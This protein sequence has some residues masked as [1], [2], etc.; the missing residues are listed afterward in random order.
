M[1][2][3]WPINYMVKIKYFYKK[4]KKKCCVDQYSQMIKFNWKPKI[5]YLKK[6]YLKFT[7]RELILNKLQL[8]PTLTSQTTTASASIITK[9]NYQQQV[10]FSFFWERMVTILIWYC[11]CH[12]HESCGLSL[13]EKNEK[14]R[15]GLW[16]LESAK[17]NL[18]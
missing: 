5:Q 15:C 16:Q 17:L 9:P 3:P 11:T 13:P 1:W 4:K 10:L 8:P 2:W 14:E 6:L 7:H 12:V 18:I